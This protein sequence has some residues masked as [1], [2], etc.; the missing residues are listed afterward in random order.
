MFSQWIKI[1]RT[2]ATSSDSCSWTLWRAQTA[3]TS[4]TTCWRSGSLPYH[5]VGSKKATTR[6]LAVVAA[7][8][9]TSTMEASFVVL[10][11][12][13]KSKAHAFCLKGADYTSYVM[14]VLSIFE[15]TYVFYCPKMLKTDCNFT[16][17]QQNLVVPT[18][19]S[20][21]NLYTM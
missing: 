12:R 8:Y 4:S 14:E 19:S 5:F 7:K 17:N 21:T 6:R 16:S 15:K 2:N 11:S 20:Y 1:Y 3:L 18:I 13:T 10:G 9:P